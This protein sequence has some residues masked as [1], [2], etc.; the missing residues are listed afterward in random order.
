MWFFAFSMFVRLSA[1]TTHCRSS[2]VC[3]SAYCCVK[4]VVI[5][6]TYHGFANRS[7]AVA[8]RMVVVAGGGGEEDDN[9]RLKG[10]TAT[11][12]F[13]AKVAVVCAMCVVIL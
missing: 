2:S 8:V 12:C 4:A 10:D 6:N 7:I 9:G 13:P 11:R 5:C 3:L 1:S